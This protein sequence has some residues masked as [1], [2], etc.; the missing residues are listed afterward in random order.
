MTS[1]RSP[2]YFSLH[3]SDP[4]DPDGGTRKDTGH[5]FICGP[6]GSGKTVLVG[7]LLAMLARG[8]VTQVVFDKDRGLE[9]ASSSRTCGVFALD[10]LDTVTQITARNG[11]DESLGSPSKLEGSI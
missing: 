3:A 7:F 10:S 5:T 11:T 8:G 6:T 9:S 4:K 1:S 2:Y